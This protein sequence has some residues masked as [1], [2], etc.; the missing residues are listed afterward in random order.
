MACAGG[1]SRGSEYPISWPEP[2]SCSSVTN[3]KRNRSVLTVYSFRQFLSFV[4]YLRKLIVVTRHKTVCAIRCSHLANNQPL[5]EGRF[6]VDYLPP[7]GLC[8]WSIDL[9][10]RPS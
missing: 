8:S 3:Y 9:P 5:P 1:A 10:S 4:S 6:Y 2:W 7:G